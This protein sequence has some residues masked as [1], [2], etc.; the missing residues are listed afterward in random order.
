[1]GA[2]ERS[3]E[4]LPIPSICRFSYSHFHSS[5]QCSISYH[6]VKRGFYMYYVLQFSHS[7]LPIIQYV[8]YGNS[9]PKPHWRSLSFK[10]ISWLVRVCVFWGVSSHQ[11]HGILRCFVNLP[12]LN[13]SSCLPFLLGRLYL[14]LRTPYIR[15]HTNFVAALCVNRV[16]CVGNG[17]M[18]C[19]AS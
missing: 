6:C 17:S 19:D 2:R 11:C 18:I 13:H 8:T 3:D 14:S 16:Y 15:L 12:T 9:H 7:I 4:N 5:C 1:M 10:Y